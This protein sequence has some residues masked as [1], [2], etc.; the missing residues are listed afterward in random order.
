MM[1]PIMTSESDDDDYD[2]F[3]TTPFAEDPPDQ[4][5]DVESDNDDLSTSRASPS[6]QSNNMGSYNN[7]QSLENEEEED[8]NEEEES[9]STTSTTNTSAHLNPNSS[10][11]NEDLPGIALLKE[12]FPEETTESLRE[13]HYQHIMTNK[14]KSTTS[15][16]SKIARRVD[17]ADNLDTNN[18]HHN[19]K[20]SVTR[21][22]EYPSPDS[23]NN[24][25]RRF[26]HVPA[27]V[28]PDDFLRLPTSVAV[29]RETT[30]A[31]SSSTATN[32]HNDSS[33][34]VNHNHDM[35]SFRI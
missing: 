21:R 29:L 11:D 13:L 10:M 9:M 7:E 28:L 30:S 1:K 15:D 33:R 19:D 32:N 16:K 35:N 22:L 5:E 26:L 34:A 23:N 3:V 31:T 14:T 6:Y 25:R 27:V 17:V 12:I 24:Q 20:E 4:E 2:K 18:K 8:D